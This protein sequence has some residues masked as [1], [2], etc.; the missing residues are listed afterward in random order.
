[1]RVPL[2]DIDTDSHT[3]IAPLEQKVQDILKVDVVCLFSGHAHQ[4][5][6]L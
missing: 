1:M 6:A 2:T 3:T 5:E 4:E